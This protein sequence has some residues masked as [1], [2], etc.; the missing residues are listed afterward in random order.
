MKFL[1][2]KELRAAERRNAIADGL[3]ASIG[4]HEVSEY[5]RM[6]REIRVARRFRATL[7]LK[8]WPEESPAP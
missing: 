5:A 1:T 3:L 6:V 8:T 4:S 2:E 7:G